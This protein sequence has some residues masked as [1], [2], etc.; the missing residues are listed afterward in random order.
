MGRGGEG[1]G[2]GSLLTRFGTDTSGAS[3]SDDS[4]RRLPT[5]LGTVGGEQSGPTK[6]VEVTGRAAATNLGR[7]A[8]S[9]NFVFAL[10]VTDSP[11]VSTKYSCS[12]LVPR[13]KFC[14]HLPRLRKCFFLKFLCTSPTFPH[15]NVNYIEVWQRCTESRLKAHHLE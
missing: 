2:G 10:S 14:W 1:G 3:S 5:I 11:A 9:S 6:I 8:H 13:E 4:M 7:R 12:S 15:I